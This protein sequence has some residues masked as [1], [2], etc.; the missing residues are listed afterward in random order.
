MKVYMKSPVTRTYEVL[1]DGADLHGFLADRQEGVGGTVLTV[2]NV[3]QA[4]GRSDVLVR[5]C[6]TETSNA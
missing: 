1:L 4:P 5:I 6:L 3:D 2:T